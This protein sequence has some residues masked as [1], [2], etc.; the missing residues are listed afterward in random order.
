MNRDN[1][2]LDAIRGM[3]IEATPLPAFLILNVRRISSKPPCNVNLN[4]GGLYGMET[5]TP[6]KAG[7]LFLLR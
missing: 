3:R 7:K 1:I 6:G 4:K 2:N 5:Q